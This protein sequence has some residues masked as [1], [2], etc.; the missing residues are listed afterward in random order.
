MDIVHVRL[1]AQRGA[2]CSISSLSSSQ[3]LALLKS[4]L[5]NSTQ[6]QML[7]FVPL[8]GFPSPMRNA[9]SCRVLYSAEW[10][11]SCSL[12]LLL[13]VVSRWW[14]FMLSVCRIFLF[15]FAFALSS[16]QMHFSVRYVLKLQL[17]MLWFVWQQGYSMTMCVFSQLSVKLPSLSSQVHLSLFQKPQGAANLPSWICHVAIPFSFLPN[18]FCLA[19][20]ALFHFLF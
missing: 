19:W 18:K 7:L 3:I 8:Q 2:L 4:D 14:Y 1:P 16:F 10:W 5:G 6:S 20:S 17:S 12:L 11:K 9:G 15:I 13:L